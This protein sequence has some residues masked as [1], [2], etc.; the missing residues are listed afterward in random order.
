MDERRIDAE[1]AKLMSET[2]KL[3]KGLRWYEISMIIAG[4]L[5]VVAAVRLLV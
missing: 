4:T 1:I 2:A 5:A 3:N